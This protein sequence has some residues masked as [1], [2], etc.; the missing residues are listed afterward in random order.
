MSTRIS[1]YSIQRASNYTINMHTVGFPFVISF[2]LI[3][4]ECISSNILIKSW[5]FSGS[6]SQIIR[7]A[8]FPLQSSYCKCNSYTLFSMGLFKLSNVKY[9]EKKRYLKS[10]RSMVRGGC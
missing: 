10:V 5:S 6:R 9:F 3:F 2:S 8:S 4:K 7:P 1:R